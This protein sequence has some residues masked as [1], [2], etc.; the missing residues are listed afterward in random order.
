MQTAPLNLLEELILLLVLKVV[1]PHLG[2]ERVI[3]SLI[4][5][6]YN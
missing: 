4:L 1:L 2:Q 3:F 5:S 6:P